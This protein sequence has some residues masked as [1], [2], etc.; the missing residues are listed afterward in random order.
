MSGDLSEALS[1]ADYKKVEVIVS[2]LEENKSII[3]KIAEVI[4]GKSSATVRRY[5]KMLA[6]TGYVKVEGNTTNTR[7]VVL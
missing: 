7:Y 2:Y 4:T 5:L 3:P 1:E 6:E